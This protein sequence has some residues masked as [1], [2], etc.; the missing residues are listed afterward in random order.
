MS[1][2]TMQSRSDFKSHVPAEGF[3]RDSF[4]INSSVNDI[5]GTKS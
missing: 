2:D 4:L 3:P 1:Q 5:E